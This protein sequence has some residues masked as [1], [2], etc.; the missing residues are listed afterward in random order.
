MQVSPYKQYKYRIK[1]KL[2]ELPY[3][4]LISAKKNL[5]K[6]LGISFGS[7]KRYIYYKNGNPATIPADHLA[8]LARFF[9]C[10]TD[11]MFNYELPRASRKDILHPDRMRIAK[12]HNLKS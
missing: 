12:K 7:F 2:E 8:I 10:K 4:E 6:I 5:P 11:D 3:S 9:N 1:E